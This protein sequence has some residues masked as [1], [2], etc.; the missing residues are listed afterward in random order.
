M[1]GRTEREGL[2]QEAELLLRSL[3]PDAHER[4][5]PLLHVAA[6]DTDGAATDLVA[7]ADDVVGVGEG[8]AGVGV[9]GVEELRPG[10]GEG[11]V[12]GGPLPRAH[13]DV[14]RRGRRGG[15]LEQGRVDD[16]DERPRLA[17]GRGVGGLE[18][19]GPAGDLV[20]GGTQQRACLRRGPGPEEDAVPH[21]G[22]H[23]GDQARPLVV[24]Q[25]LGHGSTQLDR[26]VLGPGDEHVGQALGA[27]LLGPLLPGVQH[28]ARLR[29]APGHHD[30][31]DVTARVLLLEHPERRGR[32]VVGAVG[33]LEV[34]P[35]V[36]LVAAVA[37]HRVGVGDARDG[38]GDLVPDQG[39]Q[40]PQHV[41][42]DGDDVVLLDEAHLHVELGELRLPVGAEVLVPVAAG[43]LVVP[44]QAAD[45]EQLLEQLG[46]L[47]Q[48]VEGARPQPRGHHEV[49]GPLGGGPGEGRRLDLDE[50]VT[51]QHRARGLVDLAAQPH[52]SGRAGTAQVQVPV[53]EARLLPD[54]HVLVHLERQRGR[55][56]QHLDLGDV[57]LDLAGR[58]GG[59]LVARRAPAYGADD[60]D[61]VLVAQ[62]VRAGGVEDL[63]ADDHLDHARGVPQVDE[64][65]PTVVASAGHPAG[66]GDGGSGLGGAE[67]AGRV[68][69]QQR[70]SFDGGNGPGPGAGSPGGRPRV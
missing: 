43:D 10:R 16:P 70:V 69:T 11:V 30:G 35:Q 31:A 19:A 54:L 24:G 45:H 61:A 42:P 46:A 47:R 27:A 21:G 8:A 6:V 29:G 18:Q 65:D 20:A 33:E 67:G 44:L 12:D 40:R 49:P 28:L 26:A 37:G 53:L 36:G 38:R 50:T 66:E 1:R 5:H 34:E 25:V 68:G 39:P 58:Q 32:E 51:V 48:R 15:R 62:L 23:V 55:G 52:R 57:D 63:V 59:V 64:G 56:A 7:V 22:T 14:A 13:R 4:E 60:L 9:E 41:L 2:Q 3:G 17:T